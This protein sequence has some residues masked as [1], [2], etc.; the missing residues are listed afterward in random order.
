M[1]K[2]LFYILLVSALVSVGYF[3]HPIINPQP[4]TID[5][6]LTVD[7]VE[8]SPKIENPDPIIVKAQID[9]MLRDT[10]NKIVKRLPTYRDTTVDTINQYV[11]YAKTKK[12]HT[13]GYWQ[14]G[15]YIKQGEL[16]AWYLYPP[17]EEFVFDW[18]ANPPKIERI[19]NTKVILQKQPCRATFWNNKYVT[20]GLGVLSAVAFYETARR[21]KL[22][23]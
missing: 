18:E 8:V 20:Y 3:L 7:T 16:K 19:T 17:D 12:P 14:D 11:Y 9:S 4:I 22:V 6:T 21:F 15:E 13:L 5:S 1:I 2:Y 23:D 10:L